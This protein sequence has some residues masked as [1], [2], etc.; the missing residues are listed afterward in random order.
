MFSQ[1]GHDIAKEF[2]VLADPLK[3][4]RFLITSRL[5]Q[6]DAVLYNQ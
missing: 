2:H 4:I 1:K 5:F 6:M 3:N